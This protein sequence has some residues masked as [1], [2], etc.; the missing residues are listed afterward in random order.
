MLVRKAGLEPASLAALAPKASVFAISPLP[1]IYTRSKSRGKPVWHAIPRRFE[2]PVLS[3]YQP[4]IRE[5]RCTDAAPISRVAAPKMIQM[6]SIFLSANRM[7]VATAMPMVSGSRTASRA[8]GTLD[9]HSSPTLASDH[10]LQHR[11]RPRM[12]RVVPH[13]ANQRNHQQRWRDHRQPAGH[14]PRHA[15]HKIAD[16]HQVEPRG[17]RRHPRHDNRRVQLPVG[18]HG[19]MQHQVLPQIGSDARPLNDVS[20]AFSR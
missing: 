16:A 3:R 2:P 5:T 13:Q 11:P 20:V 10:R 14:G 19:M 12:R 1:H 18:E 17:A 7:T 6:L 8:S 15:I 4:P 9:A